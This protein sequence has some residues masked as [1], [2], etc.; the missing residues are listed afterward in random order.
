M[1]KRRV[2]HAPSRPAIPAGGDAGKEGPSL[3]TRTYVWY[4]PCPPPED[5]LSRSEVPGCTSKDPMTTHGRLRGSPVRRRVRHAASVA[6][7]H[8][9]DRPLGPVE[10][11][12]SAADSVRG[13]ALRDQRLEGPPVGST[14][15][16][17][18]S[19]VSEA[20]R[21]GRLG[22]DKAVE[23]TRFAT[24]DTEANLLSG[25]NRV[26]AGAIRSRG[27]RGDPAEPG[28]DAGNRAFPVPAVV[29]RGRG[30]NPVSGG[31][32]SCGRRCGG[33]TSSG[34]SL[35]QLPSTPEGEEH[36]G[37]DAL[38]A[39]RSPGRR[40]VA[41]ACPPESPPTPIRTGRRSSRTYHSRC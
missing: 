27:D 3:D 11:R 13:D 39:G 5:F 12:R 17:P 21:S 36:L 2:A 37:P 30:T 4:V 26:S 19:R 31:P 38:L 16:T 9:G 20:L 15:P 22:M 8:C 33:C 24:P 35:H 23:F 41:I 7:R 10:G 6:A 28:G 14:P 40:L 25:P 29:A 32:L 34:A 1:T 18:P